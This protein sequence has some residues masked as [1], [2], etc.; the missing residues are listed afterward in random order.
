[1]YWEYQLCHISP[2]AW[3]NPAPTGRILKTLN[4]GVFFE[5][6][7]GKLTFLSGKFKFYYNLTRITG[8]LH[9]D[10]YAFRP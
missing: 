8:T 7:S 4:I 5:N 10:Q 3:N 1:M 9:E 2:S 6:L